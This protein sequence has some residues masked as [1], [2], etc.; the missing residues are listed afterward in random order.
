MPEI[1]VKNNAVNIRLCQTKY[2]AYIIKRGFNGKFTT[3]YDGKW[4]EIITD[5]PEA[6]IYSYTVTPY[7]VSENKKICGKEITLPLVSIGNDGNS[8]QIKIPDIANKNWYD[9]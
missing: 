5:S 1:F 6:G 2:Y 4:K 8:P 3:I 7:F 9:L